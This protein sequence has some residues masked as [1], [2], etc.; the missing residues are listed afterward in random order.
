MIDSDNSGGEKPLQGVV[1]S[2][3]GNEENLKAVTN[4][5][6]YFKI[7][8]VP[9]GRF[10]VNVDGR[11]VNVTG[12]NNSLPWQE[13]SYYAFVGKAW[14]AILGKDNNATR[15]GSF[16]E[17]GRYIDDPRDG[18]IYLPLVK[19][20]ALQVVDPTQETEIKFV[21][22]YL[23]EAN[24]SVKAM[25]SATSLTIPP[26]S[27]ISDNG[28][29]GGS[30]GIAPV[31]ANRLP[32]PL[33]PGLELPLVITIQ[34]DGAT[35]FDIPIP[36][37]FPNVDELEPGAKSA[38]WSFDHDKGK[39]EIAGPMTVSEDGLFVSTD[40]GVGIRQPGWHGAALGA[41]IFGRGGF[42][43][44]PV[45]ELNDQAKQAT[46]ESIRAV[47]GELREFAQYASGIEESIF[48]S[49]RDLIRQALNF[50]RNKG[51]ININEW[52]DLKST[53]GTLDSP[54][55]QSAYASG[56][57]QLINKEDTWTEF[58]GR[59]DAI[60]KAAI[61]CANKKRIAGSQAMI[62]SRFN[63]FVE[64]LDSAKENLRKQVSMY[65]TFADTAVL[66][67][68]LFSRRHP[69]KCSTI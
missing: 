52:N 32:E 28:T 8:G 11:D 4:Q 67:E 58:Y 68:R 10:F 21:D 1:V 12:Q 37:T 41:Q 50:T 59:A 22:G 64:A 29:A 35:N 66:I 15:Y 49:K 44:S 38:L 42:C 34:T 24:S 33:P 55:N 60:K 30:V 51:T 9:T 31:P 14:E 26:G 40:P 61:H 23:E 27:L 43:G 57:I 69:S 17:N 54:A 3:P 6:G 5:D 46:L 18:K 63:S 20:G 36:A 25:M 45:E 13:R 53:V 16:D 19:K 62:Q 47:E 2:V 65:Q 56:L 48:L 7:S 39:W